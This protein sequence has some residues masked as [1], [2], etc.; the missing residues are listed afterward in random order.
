MRTRRNSTIATAAVA[1]ALLCAAC[2]TPDE[3]SA[4]GA[5]APSSAPSTVAAEDISGPVEI[6]DR[7]LFVECQGSTAPTV[8]MEAGLT[9]DHRTWEKVLPALDA[10]TST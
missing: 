6:G 2:G 7:S 9:G 4:A 3:Q 8:V 10:D 1:V 5:P